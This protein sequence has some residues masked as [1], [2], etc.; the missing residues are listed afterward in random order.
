M[1]NYGIVTAFSCELPLNSSCWTMESSQHSLVSSSWIAHAGVWI[2]TAL[3]HELLLNEWLILDYGI[4][5]TLSREFRRNEWLM[6]DY[7]FIG[8]SSRN[9]LLKGS[10][11]TTESSQHSQVNLPWIVHVELWNHHSILSWAPLEL[12]MLEYG[13]PQHYHMN[14]SWMNDSFWTTESS[15]HC[16]VNSAGMNGSCWTIYSSEKAHATPSWKAHVGLWNHH[17]I[18][19]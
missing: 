1:L 19:T 13:L 9:P 10:C 5:T 6:L 2:T 18:L 11:W 8:E 15:Q 14:S 4:I 7:L 12:L 17:C 3:S 16:H